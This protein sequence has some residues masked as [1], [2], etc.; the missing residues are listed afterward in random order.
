MRTITRAL[1]VVLAL[2]VSAAQAEISAPTACVNGELAI[3][4]T[5]EKATWAVY[6]ATYRTAIY[7]SDDGKTCVFAS[8]YKGTVTFIAASIQGEE[9]VIDQHTLYNGVEAPEPAPT[10]VPTPNPQPKPEPVETLEG[11]TKAEAEKVKSENKVAEIEAL[12]SAFSEVASG[13][14]RGTVKSPEGAR[15]TFRGLW[16]EKAIQISENSLTTW[17]KAV[18]A[19]SAKIDN[20][21]ITTIKKDY[22]TVAKALGELIPKTAEPAGNSTCPNGQ[23]PN[24]PQYQTYRPGWFR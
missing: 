14:D 6:P 20:T 1:A 19:I 13:I 5:Q 8:P 4:K 23:C 12:S 17:E 16:V 11:V 21:S 7:V 24:Q 3:L 18:S 22:T 2:A 10:P 9:V 15:A